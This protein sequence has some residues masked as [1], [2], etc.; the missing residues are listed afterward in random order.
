A[1]GLLFKFILIGFA[2]SGQKT[3]GAIRKQRGRGIVC[4]QIFQSTGFQIRLQVPVGFRP[5]N[6]GMPGGIKIMNKAEIRDF[7]RADIAA[8]P[9]IAFE[10][11]DVPSLLGEK[12][13]P[14]Q[15]IDSTADK[16]CV[17]CAVHGQC[18]LSGSPV[19]CDYFRP[20]KSAY[21]ASM[22]MS[23]V[24]DPAASS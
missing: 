6:Q 16:Y 14:C 12:C 5:N 13:R 10:D 23:L 17:E 2:G 1:P 9:R 22:N 20:L 4:I 18:R 21:M 8:E 15:G 19:P 24:Q 3:R 11:A 7:R